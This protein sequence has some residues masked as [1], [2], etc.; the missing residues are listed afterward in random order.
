M[1]SSQNNEIQ[2]I[3]AI[4]QDL[5]DLKAYPILDMPRGAI[6]LDAMENPYSLTQSLQQQ[7]AIA[8]SQSAINRYPSSHQRLQET[9]FKYLA[10]HEQFHK[11]DN[12]SMICGNGS[13]EIIALLTQIIPQ[14]AKILSPTPCFVMY[15]INARIFERQ[16]IGV[17]L[18]PDFNLDVP[19]MQAM[20]YSQRPA[21]IYL[22]YPNNPTGNCFKLEDINALLETVDEIKKINGYQPLIVFDEAYSIFTGG[23]SYLNHLFDLIEKYPNILILR[24][25][26]KLGLAGLRL[27]Y[28][29][30]HNH[31]IDRLQAIR[32]PYN[33]NVLTYE[34]ACTLLPHANVFQEQSQQ[35]IATREKVYDFLKTVKGTRQISMSATNFLVWQ[36]PFAEHFY[37]KL[38]AENIFIKNISKM[39]A[40]LKNC[41][42][43]SIGSEDEMASFIKVIQENIIHD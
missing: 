24:T 40:L 29:I 35:I 10:S 25:F 21:L 9:I 31:L 7:L 4:R 1:N 13:D 33:I 38:L 36:H 34:A 18:L 32:P 12:I 39:H 42:R 14:Q 27:G 22:P 43:I 3:S 17:D 5:H 26:S 28:A 11:N 16:F 2:T 41:L 20:I 8:L 6:K 19:A 37:Q 23:L 15:Q 30:A